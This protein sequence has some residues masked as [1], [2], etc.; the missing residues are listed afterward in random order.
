MAAI[1]ALTDGRAQL[2]MDTH[3]WSLSHFS[4]ASGVDTMFV[5]YGFFS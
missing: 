2:Q 5:V 1:H 4:D 3:G